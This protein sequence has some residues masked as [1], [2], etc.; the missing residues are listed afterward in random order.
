MQTQCCTGAHCSPLGYFTIQS[1]IPGLRRRGAARGEMAEALVRSLARSF[2]VTL[3]NLRPSTVSISRPP[4]LS[5]SLPLFLSS[6][7]GGSYRGAPFFRPAVPS[8][9]LENA[10]LVFSLLGNCTR[11][12]DSSHNLRTIVSSAF[13]RRLVG[14]VK[15]ETAYNSAAKARCNRHRYVNAIIRVAGDRARDL[16]INPADPYRFSFDCRL[17]RSREYNRQLAIGDLLA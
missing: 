16:A 3:L 7:P 11:L 9:A 17:N 8:R 13:V 4:T 15:P 6:N 14:D 5:L 2:I 12:S 10:T 1:A